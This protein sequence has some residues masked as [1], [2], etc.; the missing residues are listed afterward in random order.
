MEFKK[1][2][3]VAIAALA[4]VASQASAQ[5]RGVTDLGPAGPVRGPAGSDPGSGPVRS[6]DR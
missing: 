5:T 3:M 4:A 1:S 2:T 6:L